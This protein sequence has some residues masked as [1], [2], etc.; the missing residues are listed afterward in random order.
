[1]FKNL[2]SLLLIAVCILSNTNAQ[3]DS[4]TIPLR[5]R[6]IST[7]IIEAALSDSVAFGRLEELCDRFGHRFSG[8]ENLEK[9]I[10]WI[11]ERLKSDG[12]QNVTGQP[13]LV[14]KWVRGKEQLT[15]LE[16]RERSLPLLGLGGSIATPPGG[17]KAEVIVVRDFDELSR[18]SAEVKGKIVL[19]NVPFTTYGETV[20]YRSIGAISAARYGAVASLIRSVGTF[21]MQTPHT[22]AMRYNDSIAKIP[23]AAITSED[24][25]MLA[26]LHERG[27][28]IVMHL[29]MEARTEPDVLSRNVIAEIVGSLFPDQVVVVGGHIDSWDVGQG[30]HDDAGSCVAAW[31]ALRLIHTLGLRP[32]RTIRLVL[33]TN[34]E[35]G[36]RGATTYADS[37]KNQI[38]KHTLA[39]E[40][41][42]G[43]FKPLGFGFGGSDSAYAI[44]RAVGSLLQP[45]EAHE[46]TKG[47]GGADIGTL[48]RKG[49]PGMGLRLAGDRYFW[50]HHTDA[51][52]VDKIDRKD[53]NLCAAA[54]AVMCYV[55]ADL[56]APLPR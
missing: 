47:G 42:A 41:D 32:K 43:T 50:Y 10:D 53:L 39:I 24:A 27:E 18:R 6:G 14:P 52:T 55:I 8:S 25:A 17:V 48:M 2:S 23:H 30:A 20:Q 44:V 21:S 5:Y 29:S 45:I 56:P 13:V 37:V 9:A 3:S 4:S 35:N 26:R 22:G 19:Y 28:K 49:V 1:M 7:Q 34:E 33:W 11:L 15:L 46:I 40:A 12:L 54:L 31:Q 51:D 16:P 36:L 38:D